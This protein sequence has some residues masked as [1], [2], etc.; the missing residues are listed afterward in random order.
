MTIADLMDLLR[1]EDRLD[2]EAHPERQNDGVVILLA[3]D[4]ILARL[5]A[6]WPNVPRSRFP[7]PSKLLPPTLP[8]AHSLR[9]L[10]AHLEPDPIPVWLSTA[11]LPDRP[12]NVKRCWVAIENKMVFPDGTRSKWAQEFIARKVREAL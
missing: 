10:W 5:V 3:H 6:A 12:D 2:S 8:S 1:V 7:D 9:W 4:A 11:G